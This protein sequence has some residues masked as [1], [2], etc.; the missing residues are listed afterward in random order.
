MHGGLRSRP[1]DLRDAMAFKA[2]LEA[3]PGAGNPGKQPMKQP[4]V[5]PRLA[6]IAEENSALL[7]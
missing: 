1:A 2:P 6:N 3:A 4:Q 7:K 5:P